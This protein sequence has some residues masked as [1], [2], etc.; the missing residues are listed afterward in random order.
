MVA[1]VHQ[2][3]DY[4]PEVKQKLETGLYGAP[5]VDVAQKLGLDLSLSL[6]FQSDSELAKPLFDR[7][8]TYEFFADRIG[9]IE[10]FWD[11]DELVRVFFPIPHSCF[12]FERD[13]TAK[14]LMPTVLRAE[15]PDQ[16]HHIYL[17][18][19]E[20][21]KKVVDK[22]MELKGAGFAWLRNNSE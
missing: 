14:K 4:N 16:Q 8:E 12:Q 6:R 15:T 11:D 7:I 19:F 20:R 1:L 13:E 2:L 22:R 17:E 5:L 9:Q 21:L 10:I 3:M 18:I